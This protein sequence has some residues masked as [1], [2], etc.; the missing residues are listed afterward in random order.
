[1]AKRIYTLSLKFDA[2]Q[3]TK[4][5]HYHFDG[6]KGSPFQPEGRLAGTYHFGAG[7]ALHVKVTATA[8][9]KDKAKFTV[10]DFTLASI[11]TLQPGKYFLSLFDQYRACTRVTDWGVP[12]M[13]EDDGDTR[14]EITVKALHP[15]MITAPNGQW[16]ISGYLSVLIEKLDKDGQIKQIPRLFY[17]DPEG[18]SG[19]GGDIED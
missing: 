11:P 7:D 4:A 12:V 3:V 15:L 8:N 10:T 18:S 2:D 6:P 1:M 13:G 9:K 16:E 17:F 19:S 5:L 14:D